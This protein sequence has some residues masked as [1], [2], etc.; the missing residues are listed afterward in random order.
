[1]RRKTIFDAIGVSDHTDDRLAHRP[2]SNLA[3]QI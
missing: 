1:L 2:Q 3:S